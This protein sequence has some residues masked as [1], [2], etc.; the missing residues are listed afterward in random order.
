MADTHTP[1][2]AVGHVLDAFD[3]ALL[4]CGG[5]NEASIELVNLI[6]DHAAAKTTGP[7]PMNRVE[8]KWAAYS[9]SAM[10]DGEDNVAVVTMVVDRTGVI[11][12][13]VSTKNLPDAVGESIRASVTDFL[14]NVCGFLFKKPFRCGCR[15]CESKGAAELRDAL[16][17]G[18]AGWSQTKAEA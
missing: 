4:R 7:R 16:A 1:R 3:D 14:V 9:L 12:P 18:Q 11:R 15:T 10:M 2:E 17:A 5:G 13:M 8:M 6:L